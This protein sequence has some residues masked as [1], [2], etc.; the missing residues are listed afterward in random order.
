MVVDLGDQREQTEVD[1]LFH[2]LADATRR[3]IVALTGEREYS[4]SALARI[5]PMSFAAVQ[6]HVAILERAHLV[7]KQKR[8]R[9]QIVRADPRGVRDARVVLDRLEHLWRGRLGRF[10]DVLADL[11][12]P[13]TIHPPRVTRRR[14]P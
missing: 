2:A 5:Y 8:G 11:D 13:D 3:D 7:A 9:E 1:L 6:K 12:A 10:G 4:V 14:R